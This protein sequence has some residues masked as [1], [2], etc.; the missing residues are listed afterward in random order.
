[1][2][3]IY[4]AAGDARKAT[5]A[6]ISEGSANLDMGISFI[7]SCDNASNDSPVLAD[8]FSMIDFKRCV[9]VAPGYTLFTV[10]P[11]GASSFAIVLLQFATAAR[12][13]FDTPRF[14]NGTF[15]EV[16]MILMIRPY[17]SFFIPSTT[18]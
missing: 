6:A 3:V 9:F 17:F 1:M 4:E 7:I 10:I 13:V 5:A 12:I 14:F 15:T 11:K 2:P 8:L 18:A 16:E